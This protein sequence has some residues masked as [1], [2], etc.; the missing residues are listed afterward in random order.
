[1]GIQGAGKGTQVALLKEYLNHRDEHGTF[2]FETGDGFRQLMVG[3]SYT[4]GLVKTSMEKGELQPVFLSVWLW[5]RAFVHDFTGNEHILIDGFPRSLFEAQVLH[6]A[7][8]FY[9]LHPFTVIFLNISDEEALKRLQ[10]RGRHDDTPDS[11]ARRLSWFRESVT[12]IFDWYDRRD[13]YNFV[14]ING[15]QSIEKVH[16]DIV[17]AIESY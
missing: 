12:P 15:E 10:N 16:Q 6:T 2:S 4:A 17:K 5:S 8:E 14:K 13:D 7:F 9:D 3:E 11:I 1:M